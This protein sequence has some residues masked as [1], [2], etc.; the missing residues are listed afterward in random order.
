MSYQFGLSV[1]HL[2]SGADLLIPEASFIS[3]LETPMEI[4]LTI[5]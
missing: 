1:V 5:D 4:F 2:T 3:H